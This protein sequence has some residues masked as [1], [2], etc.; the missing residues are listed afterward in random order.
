[1][2]FCVF[3]CVYMCVCVY[4]PAC[5]HVCMCAWSRGVEDNFRCHSQEHHQ[6]PLRQDLSNCLRAPQLCCIKCPVKLRGSPVSSSQILHFKWVA[7]CPACLD[8]PNVCSTYMLARLGF[9]HWAICPA[10]GH[11][12]RDNN[13]NTEWCYLFKCVLLTCGRK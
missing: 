8:V 9:T 11:L 1:V 13:R 5:A 10:S 4:M 12:K 2:H 6:C 7:L 3:V